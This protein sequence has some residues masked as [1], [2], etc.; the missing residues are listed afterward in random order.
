MSSYICVLPGLVLQKL[1]ADYGQRLLESNVR[2]FLSFRGKVNN[3]MRATLLKDP[4]SFFAYNN[5]LNCY[6]KRNKNNSRPSFT[7][8][9]SSREYAN[10]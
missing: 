3:G 2:T 10:C 4:E 5:G 1:F 9:Y 7:S 6:S 8:Y